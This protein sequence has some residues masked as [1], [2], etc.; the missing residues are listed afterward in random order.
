MNSWESQF[1]R[2]RLIDHLL[3]P[4]VIRRENN[5]VRFVVDYHPALRALNG[6]FRELQRIVNFSNGFFENNAGTVCGFIS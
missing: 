1:E 5:R 4:I 6:I 3:S 2:V